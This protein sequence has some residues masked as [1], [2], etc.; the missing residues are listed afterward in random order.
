MVIPGFLVP[1]PTQQLTRES[2]ARCCRRF[3]FCR[4]RYY[5]RTP[6]FCASDNGLQPANDNEVQPTSDDE[7]QPE[8]SLPCLTVPVASGASVVFP[9][10]MFF[11][12]VS[13][14]RGH[15][16]YQV[17][18]NQ[19][20]GRLLLL[21]MDAWGEPANVGCIAK[22]RRILKGDAQRCTILF[23]ALER[24][25]VQGIDVQ[26]ALGLGPFKYNV[27][28][29]WGSVFYDEEEENRPG[30]PRMNEG[31]D[32]MEARLLETMRSFLKL[33]LKNNKTHGSFPHFLLNNI[34]VCLEELDGAKQRPDLLGGGSLDVLA[35]VETGFDW[36]QYLRSQSPHRLREI[37]SFMG[38]DLLDWSFMERKSLI[39]SRNV[40]ER[41]RLAQ[42]SL[43]YETQRLAAKS[44]IVDAIG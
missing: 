2:C 19:G 41:L 32:M 14:S 13:D 18:D 26:P 15:D 29:A 9:G 8:I 16:W 36:T 33:M 40:R 22:I 37:V 3:Y 4:A 1:Y 21:A 35:G 31:L 43:E 7:L 24:F 12:E 17:V 10:I 28:R 6:I 30:Q 5:Q 42:D 44:A 38:L 25:R 27:G 23:A 20:D 34:Q 39:A 11:T